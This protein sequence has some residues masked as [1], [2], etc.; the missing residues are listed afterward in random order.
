MEGV[1]VVRAPLSISTHGWY[2]D[3]KI[4]LP[5][6]RLLPLQEL[7]WRQQGLRD[8]VRHEYAHAFADFHCGLLRRLCFARVFHGGYDSEQ[9][10]EFDEEFH[11]SQ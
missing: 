2:E 11:V 5:A 9:E 3:G 4:F 10:F 7:F 8:L 1:P 6:L